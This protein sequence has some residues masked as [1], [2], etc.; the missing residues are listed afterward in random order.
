M[1]HLK[2]IKI[3]VL[4]LIF[5][6]ISAFIFLLIADAATIYDQGTTTYD[7]SK[8]DSDN[9]TCSISGYNYGGTNTTKYSMSYSGTG[10]MKDRENGWGR[11]FQTVGVGTGITSIGNYAF[12][13]ITIN[14]DSYSLSIPNTVTSIGSYAFAYTKDFTIVVIPDSVMYIG[15]NAFSGAT[16]VIIYCKAF[17]QPTT[18]DENWNPDNCTVVWKYGH[19]CSYSD[20]EY[21]DEANH[22]GYCACGEIDILAHDFYAGAC[23]CGAIEDLSTW[24]ISANGDG[25]LIAYLISHAD[26]YS[27][28]I[29]GTGEMI[30]WNSSTE[31]PWYSYKSQITSIHM[32]EGITKIGKYAFIDFTCMTNVTIP[33]SVTT[34]G[35]YSFANCT[36]LASVKMGQG[37]ININGQAF[38]YCSN[39]VDINIPNGVTSIFS[40]AFYGCTSLA[41]IVL[42]D[43]VSSIYTGA[44]TNCPRLTIYASAP[45]KPSGWTAYWNEDGRP[46]VWG[47]INYGITSDGLKWCGTTTKIYILGLTGDTTQINIPD[48]INEIPVK[49]ISDYAFYKNDTVKNVS[50]GNSVT[51]IG[52][53]AFYGCTSLSSLYIGSSVTSISDYAFYNCRSLSFL[54]LPDNVKYIYKYAFAY[55]SGIKS[56]TLGQSVTT[57]GNSAFLGCVHLEKI[58]FNATQMSN[59]SSMPNHIFSYAGQNGNGI[60]LII[61]KKVKSIPNSLFCP[62]DYQYDTRYVPNIVNARF[63]AN[64]ECTSIGSTAFSGCDKLETIAIPSSVTTISSYA[65]SNCSKLTIYC[66]SASKSS[67]WSQYWNSGFCTVVYNY[68]NSIGSDIFSFKGYS[69]GF[70]GQIS[71]GY[72]IDY[73]ARLLYEALTGET[74]EIGVVFAGYDNLGGN[75]PLD[76]NGQVIGL[77][78]GKVIKADLTSLSYPSYDFML[79]DIDDSIKDVKLV[80]AAYIYDQETV[81]YVQEN[82]LINTVTGVS[83]NEAKGSVA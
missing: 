19:T 57:L 2:S 3:K 74:L 1:V 40:N 46:T 51:S 6:S 43:S 55:C 52:D 22:T 37:V 16:N 8:T 69:F 29:S 36:G 80:I 7:Y 15:E 61:G 20:F 33:N 70:A 72:D 66:E 73:E 45:S 13:G 4:S 71:V 25:S 24:D 65:F 79:T 50:I 38:W 77:S 12:A 64:S 56:L 31:V 47:C 44:F 39:L 59:I 49:S 41:N 10:E 21:V 26:T 34:I 63:E 35:I 67:S 53:Y 17:S 83:Y 11:S 60:E 28:F 23:A 27:L 30:D 18:W 62:Y 68:K 48:S 81:K 42:P 9:V 14:G 58:N 5:L 78:V 82:G 75:Q 54:V 32:E 76:Q